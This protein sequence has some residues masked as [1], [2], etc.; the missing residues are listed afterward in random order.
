MYFVLSVCL[1]VQG[2]YV[3]AGCAEGALHVWMWETSVEICHIAAHKQR[4][5]HCS[6]LLNPGLHCRKRS[7][8]HSMLFHFIQSNKGPGYD[9]PVSLHCFQDKKEE[10]TVFTA[11][12]DGTVQLWKPLEVRLSKLNKTMISIFFLLMYT[13][14]IIFKLV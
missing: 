14:H 10:M 2:Q 3:I 4:I 12:D 11:S 1:C 8:Y 5:Q 9:I 7:L 13:F 6:L